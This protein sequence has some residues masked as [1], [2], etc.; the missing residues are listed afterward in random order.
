MNSP[1][2]PWILAGRIFSIIGMSFTAAI[3]ILLAIV[4]HWWAI[5][6]AL[7]FFPFLGL[8]IFVEKFS[9]KQGWI[10]PEIAAQDAEE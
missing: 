9:S 5:P 3:A 10:G 6:A 4:P 7:A 1:V 8:I 2:T